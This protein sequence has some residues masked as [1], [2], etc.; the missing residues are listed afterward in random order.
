M[1][2]PG[3]LHIVDIL[4][5]SVC[6]LIIRIH[7]KY[8]TVPDLIQLGQSIAKGDFP[9][10]SNLRIEVLRNTFGRSDYDSFNRDEDA[11]YVEYFLYNVPDEQRDSTVCELAKRVGV[12]VRE[13]FQG[14]KVAVEVESVYEHFSL[15]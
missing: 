3:T 6:N 15:Q 5:G 2:C 10:L 12:R 7:D 4:P 8:K 9:R 1:L 11:F 13:A 14:T